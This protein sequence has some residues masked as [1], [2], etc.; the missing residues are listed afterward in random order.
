MSL[1]QDA[2]TKIPGCKTCRFLDQYGDEPYDE[3]G[4]LADQLAEVL[5]LAREGKAT[6]AGIERALAQRYHRSI[7]P[8]RKSLIYHMEHCV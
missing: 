7:A 2:E 1:R 3:D 5:V 8:T 4:T 6:W